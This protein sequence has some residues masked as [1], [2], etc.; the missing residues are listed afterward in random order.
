[1]TP[2]EEQVTTLVLHRITGAGDWV[3]RV[4]QGKEQGVKIEKESV[5]KLIRERGDEE[6]GEP[7]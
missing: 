1:M 6:A 5:L 4:S 3:G 2:L 7:G